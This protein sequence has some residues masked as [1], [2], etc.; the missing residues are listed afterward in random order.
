MS[1][2]KFYWN[3]KSKYSGTMRSE[4]EFGYDAAVLENRERTKN[5]DWLLCILTGGFEKQNAEFIC[6]IRAYT[7]NLLYCL[8]SMVNS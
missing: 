1:D 3:I 6:V 5:L 8:P 4:D 7:E 2:A